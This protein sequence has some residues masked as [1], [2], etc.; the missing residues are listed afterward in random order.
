MLS[1]NFKRAT[2]LCEDLG[3]FLD[4]LAVIPF[5][6]FAYLLMPIVPQSVY[7]TLRL[8]RLI[9][10]AKLRPLV[11]MSDFLPKS[12]KVLL[13]I[14]GVMMAIHW[15]TSG[16]MLIYPRPDLDPVS[17]YNISL[18]WSVSTLTT[19]GYGDITPSSNIGRL[20]TIGIMLI[21]I[22]SYGIIIGNF[23]RMI[24]LADRFKEER[25]EKMATLYQYM[26][27]YNIPPTLQKQVFSFYSHI[28]NQK[29][30]QDDDQIVKDLPQALQNELEIYRK[31]KLLKE[32]HISSQSTIL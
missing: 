8:G 31:I 17:Y 23:S 30:S 18:Y 21:G 19:V 11:N 10:I 25:K 28:L 9:R 6:I 29:I 16:W 24:M 32:V 20:Y 14:T 26:K 4:I 1:K 5:D 7:L 2:F 15:M 3:F 22:A 13:V 27:Y 12:L